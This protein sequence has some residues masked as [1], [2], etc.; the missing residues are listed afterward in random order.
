MHFGQR[1]LISRRNPGVVIAVQVPRQA[2]LDAHF[3]RAQCSTASRAFSINFFG[4]VKVG[5]RSVR[6]RLNPQ[7]AQPTM[8]TLVKFKFRFTT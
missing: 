1:G 8:H 2:A 5:V 4:R 6:P 3:R 7:N